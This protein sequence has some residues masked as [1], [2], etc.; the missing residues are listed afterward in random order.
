M[1]L[2]QGSPEVMVTA[3]SSIYETAPVGGPP[4]G[5]FL[6]GACAV[7]T[8]L[9]PTALLRLLL[10]TEDRLGRV[11]RIRWGPR[12]MDL[13]LLLYGE[14][15]ITTPAL[16]VPHPRLAERDFVLIPLAEIAPAAA[17]PGMGR[18]VEEL[19]RGRPG[20]AGIRFIRG[21]WI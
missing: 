1:K 18:T 19:L 2:L 4:Q 13:D 12:T 8:S 6:N 9:R 17:V 14:C 16:V 5:P 3:L 7:E 20:S 11:R 10:N 15:I 21:P